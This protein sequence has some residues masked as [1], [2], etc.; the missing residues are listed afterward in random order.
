MALALIAK[1]LVKVVSRKKHCIGGAASFNSFF[2]TSSV[3]VRFVDEQEAR[4]LQKAKVSEKLL[5]SFDVI[6]HIQN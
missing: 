6:D 1:F 3:R 4:E 2:D 5:L